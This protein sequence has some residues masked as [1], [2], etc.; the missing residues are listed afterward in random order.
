[1]PDNDSLAEQF[2]R[3]RGHLRG[4]A[5]RIVGSLAEADDAVQEVW[6]RLSRRGG[7]SVDN[8]GAWLTTVVARVCLDML[9]S[10]KSRREDPLDVEEA[11][12]M[13][14]SH[15]P[16]QELPLANSVGLALLLSLDKLEPAERLAFVLHDR[17]ALP[18]DEIAEV[19]GRST[20]ATRQLASRARRRIQGSPP[21]QADR[22]RQREI[23]E[24]Y[25]AAAR[26]GNFDALMSLLDPNIVLRADQR[27]LGRGGPVGIRDAAAIAERAVKAGA[28]AAQPA[29]IDGE[30]G[31]IVAPRGKLLMVLKFTVA[32]GK[33]VEME[34]IADRD[35]LR[36]IDL[37]VL[38]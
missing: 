18:F 37:A 21:P 28:R 33:I 35:R 8:L 15:D 4:V 36:Q 5:Y 1:M 26:E 34:A 31:V 30:V 19:V 7:R 27:V 2:E 12:R 11:G 6:L 23:V 10:R 14:S 9:R 13:P 17:F 3:A 38:G 20:D 29:L 16:E 22:S 24:A 32:A 25:L